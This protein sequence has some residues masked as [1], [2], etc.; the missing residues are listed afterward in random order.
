MQDIL[1]PKYHIEDE[2]FS[3][4]YMRRKGYSNMQSSHY[5][6]NYE[7]YYLLRGERVY[8]IDGKVYTAQQGDMII[9]NPYDVHRTTSSE[10][11]EFERIL[12]NFT[13][14]FVQPE[15]CTPGLPLLPFAQGS[16]LVRFPIKE[17][18]GIEQLFREMLAES[19]EQREGCVHYVRALLIKLLIRIYRFSLQSAEEP[20]RYAHPM[21]EKISEIASY[22][23]SHYDQEITLEQIAKQ[24]YISPSYLSRVFKKI[25]GFHFREYLRVVRVREA[26]RRLR[27]SRDKVQDIAGSSGFEHIAHFYKTFKKM[28][29]VSPLRYRKQNSQGNGKSG[30]AA[31]SPNLS[32]FP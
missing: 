14:E 20:T 21:H 30:D 18:H 31:D 32:M 27:E 25:T 7:I 5:H 2:S 4:Q 11:P 23:N 13:H 15:V 8:F 22:L 26:Q 16:R 10:V 6:A 3:I 1:E 17:R 9:I 24:F 29:G 12:I 28:V 19:K